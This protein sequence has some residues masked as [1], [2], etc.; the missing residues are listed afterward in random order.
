MELRFEPRN[1]AQVGSMHPYARLPGLMTK[2]SLAS[3]NKKAY[4]NQEQGSGLSARPQEKIFAAETSFFTAMVKKKIAHVHRW[5]F[6]HRLVATGLL[7]L[8][9]RTLAQPLTLG[10]PQAPPPKALHPGLSQ[11]SPFRV[12]HPGPVIW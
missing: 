2:D 7:M 9:W 11:S 6:S 5:P 4:E 1:L 10:P 8:V 3:S 12:P